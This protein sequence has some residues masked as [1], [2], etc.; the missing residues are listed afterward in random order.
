VYDESSDRPRARS[1]LL[2]Q[3]CKSN[4]GLI[5]TQCS[6]SLTKR[7]A[8]IGLCGGSC[9]EMSLTATTRPCRAGSCPAPRS[10]PGTRSP[11]SGRTSLIR[12]VWANSK[13][14]VPGIS[15]RL[16]RGPPVC[17][18][19]QGGFVADAPRMARAMRER[20]SGFL[21]EF[22]SANPTASAVIVNCPSAA[23]GDALDSHSSARRDTGSCR[24]CD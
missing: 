19:L 21:L 16:P 2:R 17:R 13:I 4:H 6:G 24:L 23:V 22:V 18:A 8:V 15:Q 1:A 20:A 9:R 11:T 14:A 7:A 12:Q 10:K 5:D 3:E